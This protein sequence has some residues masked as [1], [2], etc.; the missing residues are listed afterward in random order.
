MAVVT[1]LTSLEAY[2]SELQKPGVVVIDFYSTQ[3]A[4]CKVSFLGHKG[5]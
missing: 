2:N 3:C 4:P 5:E 1:D